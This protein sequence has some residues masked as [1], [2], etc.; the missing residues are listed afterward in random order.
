MLFFVVTVGAVVG[1]GGVMFAVTYRT[2][3]E[4]QPTYNTWSP[5]RQ[6]SNKHSQWNEEN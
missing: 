6:N 5:D 3:S 1:A 4:R 2:N